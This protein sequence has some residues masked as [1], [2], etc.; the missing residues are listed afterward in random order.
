MVGA[1]TTENPAT[2]PEAVAYRRHMGSI[3][4]MVWALSRAVAV[5]LRGDSTAND[6]PAPG[7]RSRHGRSDVYRP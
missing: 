4:L 2:Q 6:L 5:A 7:S 1:S 3:V